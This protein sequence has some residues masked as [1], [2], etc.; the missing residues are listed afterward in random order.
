MAA[1]KYIFLR[2]DG[3]LSEKSAAATGGGSSANQI[4]ALNSSGVIDSTMLPA[5]AKIVRFYGS[6]AGKPTANQEL[7]AVEMKGDEVF[8]AGLT[9]NLGKCEVA[10]T[11]SVTLNIKV[12]GSTVGSMNIAAGATVATW[13]M[14]SQYTAAAGDIFAFYAPTS[15]DVTLF[16]LRYTFVGSR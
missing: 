7:F 13:T 4:P 1:D 10:P 14:A 6:F 5:E 16:G 11:G 2:T 3:T 15:V 8:P 12:N 9:S